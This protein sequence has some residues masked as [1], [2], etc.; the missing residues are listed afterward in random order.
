MTSFN[1]DTNYDVLVLGG[2]PGGYNAAFRA[3]DLGLNVVLVEKYAALGGVCLN[4]GCVPSKALLHVAGQIRSTQEPSVS[5]VELGEAKVNLDQVREFKTNT[6]NKFTSNLGLMAKQRKITVLQGEG[7]LTSA[8][9]LLLNGTD[10]Q[11][12][13]TFQQAILATGSKNIRLPFIPYE[14]K[15]ILN[16]TTALNLAEIPERL[17]I[18]GGG[19]IGMEMATVYQ[20]LGS[21]VSVAE[22]SSQ[23]M[24]GADKDL[25]KVFEQANKGRFN[26]LT[27]TQVTKIESQPEHLV[28]DYKN[29]KGELETHNFDAVLV[30]VGR[31]PNGKLAG[32]PEIGVEIDARGFIL[33]DDQCRTNLPNIFAIGD[34]TYG[35]MLAHKASH[36]AHIA[37]E[38]IAGKASYFQAKAIPGIAY[39]YPEVAWVGMTEIQAKAE[40]LDFKVASFP[41]KASARAIAAEIKHGKTKLIYDADT[42]KILGAGIVGEHAG[43]LLG[44]LTLAIEYGAELEDIALTIH[45]HPSLHESV[46]LAAELGTGSITDFPNPA[47]ALFAH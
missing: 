12:T 14:D 27:N 33:I 31:S 19:I 30:A 20:A 17:L 25:V 9:T 2:G 15:R 26:I 23:I 4:V 6:V 32:I 34:V 8:N 1:P 16:S 10:G 40:G 47:A 22:M 29:A 13:V 5:G 38:V 44:E 46:G 18:L 24:A 41:W 43:E 39:T 7:Q 3:A 42:Q 28:V 21:Q 11:L 45:A 36:Q 35:P 37:A